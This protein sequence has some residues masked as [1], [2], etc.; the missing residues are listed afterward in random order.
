MINAYS[1]LLYNLVIE[2]RTRS[3]WLFGGRRL[4]AGLSWRLCVAQHMRGGEGPGDSSD[5]SALAA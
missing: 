5:G 2:R 4:T 3:V 1:S